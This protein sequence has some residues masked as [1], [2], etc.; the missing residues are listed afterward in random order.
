V[1]KSAGN[2]CKGFFS[3]LE[4]AAVFETAALG[5]GAHVLTNA[6][7][8]HLHHDRTGVAGK[9]FNPVSRALRGARRDTFAQGI[10][11][12]IQ[13][14][15]PLSTKGQFTR[16]WLLPEVTSAA[17]LGHR[18]GERMAGLKPGA[19]YK[20]LKKLRSSVAR[21]THIKNAPIGED[22]VGAVNRTLADTTAMRFP[23]RAVPSTHDKSLLAKTE[24]K[25][26]LMSTAAGL[27]LVALT[28]GKA[29][30]HGAI[31]QARVAA[32][33]SDYGKKFTK[34]GFIKGFKD[35]IFRTNTLSKTK[36]RLIDYGLSPAA[37]DSR[38]LGKAMGMEV[39]DNPHS[40]ARVAHAIG[41]VS[42]ANSGSLAS[43][44][45]K[46]TELFE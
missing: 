31:N 44:A 13:G 26:R 29:A 22:I 27:P 1:A 41:R 11:R 6:A 46:L 42:P 9:I 8:K 10:T 28:G 43:T 36:E 39:R 32:A 15:P 20:A 7:V 12:G 33:R 35:G 17:E 25:Q 19:R 40:A 24:L 23:R 3:E 34:D 38:R 4:K 21:S 45:H 30:I 37:L 14:Q 5:A 18:A 2:F 16:A